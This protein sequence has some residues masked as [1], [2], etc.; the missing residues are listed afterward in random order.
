VTRTIK[1]P[2]GAASERLDV[3][4]ASN[5]SVSRSQIQKRIES[6]A[7]V[8]NGK[9]E[10]ASYVV[11]PGDEVSVELPESQIK[12]AINPPKIPILYE[13]DD[14]MVVDKPSG[15]SMHPGSGETTATLADFS[16]LHSADPDPDRPG[17]VHRLDKDTSGLVVIA[18]TLEAKT[19]L[20]GLFKD[21]KVKKTYALLVVGRPDKDEAIIKLPL[22]R[23]PENPLRRAVISTGREAITSYHTLANYHSFSLIEAIPQTG[24]THQLRVHFEAIGHPIAGDPIY[25]AGREKPKNLKR[26]FLHAAKLEFRLPSGKEIQVQS[27]LPEELN[28]VLGTLA[29]SS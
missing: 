9:P 11:E 15:L 28:S 23:D 22:D 21:H 13:D 4:L 1:I 3:F 8:V 2:E 18:K 7:I 14:L 19:Y 20:Q 17:I 16:K 6:G 12:Q 10:R 25:A 5:L 24:R 26:L 27:P 29:G